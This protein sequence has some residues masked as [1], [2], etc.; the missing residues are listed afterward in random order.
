MKKRNG[1][2]SI[3]IIYSFFLVFMLM[4]LL[5]LSSFINARM[6]LNIYK[7]DVKQSEAAENQ[8]V[9]LADYIKSH[10]SENANGEYRFTGTNPNNFIRFN[11]ELWRII[12]LVKVQNCLDYDINDI[13]GVFRCTNY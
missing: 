11:S 3:S 6:R 7:K 12:G 10:T 2:I 5:I 9:Y 1:F 13:S 4:L 8:D